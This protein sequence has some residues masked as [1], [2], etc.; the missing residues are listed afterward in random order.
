MREDLLDRLPDDIIKIICDHIKPSIKYNLTK[1]YFNKL[2]FLRLGYINN[3]VRLYYI[4]SLSAYQCYVIKNLNYIK[5]LLRNDLLMMIKNIIEYKLIND[6]TN[7][8]F[9]KPVIYDGIKFKNFIDLCYIL[10]IKYKSN[11]VLEF[12]NIII[13]TN[14]VKISKRLN[15]YDNS[16]SNSNSNKTNKNIKNKNNKWIA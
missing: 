15:K 8:M 5:F 11:K 12:I 3:K 9:N 16:N 14:N 13:K 1:K 2:Y 6:K 7:Y 10:S 4:K